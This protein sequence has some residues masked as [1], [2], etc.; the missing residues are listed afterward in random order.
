[1]ASPSGQARS[2][3][4]GDTVDV[5][6]PMRLHLHTIPDDPKL[7]AIL[8]GPMVLAGEL[9]RQDLDLKRLYSEDKFLHGSFPAIAVPELAGDGNALDKWIQPVGTK[10]K[11]LR[12]RK[13]DAGQPNDVTLSPFYRLFDQRYCVYWRLRAPVE[14]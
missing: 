8:Y 9:G 12:F 3:R 11:A 2:W 13:V 4:N 6:L 1:M 10:D 5:K 7:T 14:A